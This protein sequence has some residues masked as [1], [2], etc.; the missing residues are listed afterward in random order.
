MSK[1][2]EQ[3]M[4][5]RQQREVG[6]AMAHLPGERAREKV[7]FV[8]GDTHLFRKRMAG[9]GPGDP[10]HKGRGKWARCPGNVSVPQP[11]H[12]P[13]PW[14]FALSLSPSLQGPNPLS[15]MVPTIAE[16]TYWRP[17]VSSH[18]FFFLLLSAS[19][20]GPGISGKINSGGEKLTWFLGVF[21]FWQAVRK[22][23]RR[24]LVSF[25]ILFPLLTSNK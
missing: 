7:G 19:F 18:V 23:Q 8:S 17:H 10:A 4:L 12:L 2:G 20:T 21:V 15:R 24:G 16:L 13:V 22:W 9:S 5:M 25:F 1:G 11:P 6:K 14:A 3:W